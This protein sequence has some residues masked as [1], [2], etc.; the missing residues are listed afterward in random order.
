MIFNKLPGE[1]TGLDLIV[2]RVSE[3]TYTAGDLGGL[4]SGLRMEW[5]VVPVGPRSGA[6]LSC[7]SY[8]RL[9]PHPPQ[10]TERVAAAVLCTPAIEPPAAIQP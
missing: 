5:G 9:V 8:R 6:S 7:A 10:A 2:P 4:R 1:N 3:L